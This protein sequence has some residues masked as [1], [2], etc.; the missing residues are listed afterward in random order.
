VIFPKA[1]GGK[2]VVY[3]MR[4]PGLSSSPLSAFHAIL[5]ISD[6]DVTH[7]ATTTTLQQVF[8]LTASEAH[9]AVAMANGRDLETVAI[10]RQISK[11]TV[12]NQLKSVFLKTGTNRQAQLAVML[13]S[14]VPKQ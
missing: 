9:L 4:L 12:R 8:D 1:S 10:E 6:T 5:V 7:S 13:S 2:L 11:E 3:P 14:L